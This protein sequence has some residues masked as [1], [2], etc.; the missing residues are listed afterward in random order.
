MQAWIERTCAAFKENAPNHLVGIGT[1]GFTGRTRVRVDFNPGLGGSDWA[2]REG[3]DF[4]RNAATPCVGLRG[5]ARLAGRLE[6]PGTAFQRRFHRTENRRDSK[7]VARRAQTVRARGVWQN[8]PANRDGGE[9][10][11]ARGG[12]TTPTRVRYF[13]SAYALSEAAANAGALAGTLFWHWYDRGVGPGK[14][15]VR[16]T[17]TRFE[18]WKN[19]RAP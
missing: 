12:R 8:R 6:L 19:T 13:E 9:R 15:G 10:V 7:R 2:A 5:R 14:Y 3:Q 17:T 1:E 18:S 11:N 16:S 4:L